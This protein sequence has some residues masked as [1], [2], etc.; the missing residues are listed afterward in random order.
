M[1]VG[2]QK[3]MPY[4]D[5]FTQWASDPA[6]ATLM[7]NILLAV[8]AVS[9]LI[10]ALGSAVF[11]G[12]KLYAIWGAL[13]ATWAVVSGFVTATLM[14]ALGALGAALG[15]I[16]APVWIVIGAI[17]ALV[18]AGVALWKNWDTVV[19]YAQAFWGKLV[20]VFTF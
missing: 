8:G 7:K 10:V 5:K 4:L 9:G 16:S 14:P 20:E 3:L 13:S 15:A 1:T 2:M 6:N 12:G 17:A 19:Q 11:V 18:A